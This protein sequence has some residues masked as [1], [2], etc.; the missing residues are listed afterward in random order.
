M[1]MYECGPAL[2]SIASAILR[3]HC[4]FRELTSI[5]HLQRL[6]RSQGD[7]YDIQHRICLCRLCPISRSQPLSASCNRN[8]NPLGGQAVKVGHNMVANLQKQKRKIITP[9]SQSPIND[10]PSEIRDATPCSTCPGLSAR[11]CPAHESYLPYSSS[12]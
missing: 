11:G 6:V 9:S 2:V 3:F 1:Y 5:D 4:W 7:S 8:H 10:G 12:L